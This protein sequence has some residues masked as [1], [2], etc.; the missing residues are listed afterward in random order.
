VAKT[1]SASGFHMGDY[2]D[3]TLDASGEV[4]ALTLRP[5]PPP[6]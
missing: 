1:F 4:V 3:A 5:G 2:Y 6:I